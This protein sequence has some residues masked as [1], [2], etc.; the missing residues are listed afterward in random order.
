[1]PRLRR[2]VFLLLVPALLA[3]PRAVAA[4]PADGIA[5]AALRGHVYFLASDSLGGRAMSSR[6]LEVAGWYAESQLRAAGLRP[7]AGPGGAVGYLQDVPVV[8]RAPV[9]PLDVRLRTP[10]GEHLF[11]EGQAVKWFKGEIYALEGRALPVVFAGHGIGEPRHGWDDF[12]GLDVK[13]KVVVLMLGAP[14]RD[15]K[16]VL[17]EAVH[18][19]YA[20][21]SG[22][23][24]KMIGLCERQ[25]AAMVVLP[26]PEVTGAWDQLPS[27]TSEPGYE[28]DDRTPGALHV[29]SLLLTQPEFARALFEGQRQ[30]PPG[31]G[32]RGRTTT[33]PFAL[34][35]VTLGIEGRFTSETVPCRNVV[36]MVE[37]TDPALRDE[38]VVVSAH[39]DSSTP[40]KEG[41]VY[42]GADDDASGVAGLLEIAK[43]VAANPPARSVVFALFAGEEAAIIGA[44]HFVSHPPVPLERIVADVDMDMIGR[45]DAASR[46]DRAHYAI[47]SDRITPAFTDYIRD[48]NAR[49][50]G[51]PLKYQSVTG[52]S[53]DLAFIM[54][55]VPAVSFY[56]GHHE[57]VNRPTDDPEKLDYDKMEKIARLA[58][59]LTWALGTGPLPWR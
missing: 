28:Y 26:D 44:R 47:D 21:A 1:M 39:L 25:A 55:G 50:L 43:V 51:W 9:G 31:T 41:E 14:T 46:A 11:R 23:M 54:K 34:R 30:V 12:A 2:S 15:G 10:R 56:S 8:R 40:G 27:A 29:C 22:L 59:E 42:N 18:A 35:G 7:L 19:L 57:D 36:G 24:R 6:G 4:S 5:A 48:V 45:T 3:G 16:P 53:D 33:R 32:A 20:P 17:P 49:T 38:S 13:D 37:G 52:N 58:C